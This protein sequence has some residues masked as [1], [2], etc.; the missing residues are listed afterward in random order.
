MTGGFATIAGSVL[1]AY[2]SLGV[3]P[4]HFISASVMSAPAALAFSKLI[5]PETKQSR[6]T[7][8]AL[9]KLESKPAGVSVTVMTSSSAH[10]QIRCD[11]EDCLTSENSS[12]KLRIIGGG[13]MRK[14]T[15]T[16]EAGAC[17]YSNILYH[18]PPVSEQHFNSLDLK[19]PGSL[20][21]AVAQDDSLTLNT[22]L[23][24]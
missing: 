21:G 9:P 4:S 13:G 14:N 10:D 24:P 23:L 19:F 2:I 11:R 7:A 1:A 6:T 3:C 17:Y 5:Y 15:T 22:K 12:G 16:T 20:D 8:D 18:H